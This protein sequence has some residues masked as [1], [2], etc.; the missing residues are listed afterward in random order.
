MRDV[1]H[2][3]VKEWFTNDPKD[4]MT[5]DARKKF[6]LVAEWGEECYKTLTNPSSKD[7][8]LM[9]RIITNKKDV[10]EYINKLNLR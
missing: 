1:K 3:Q 10:N 5:E 2:V 6:P 4:M 9:K 7:T 8:W